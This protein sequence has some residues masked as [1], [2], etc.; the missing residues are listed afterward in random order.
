[1]VATVK[2]EKDGEIKVWLFMKNHE[3]TII[4]QN[5]AVASR[6]KGLCGEISRP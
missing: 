1:M 6:V 4:L 2:R 3:D 5:V